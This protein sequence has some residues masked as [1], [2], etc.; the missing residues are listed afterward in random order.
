VEGRQLRVE[1]VEVDRYGREV[2]RV[3]VGD[4]CVACELVRGGHAWAYREHLRDPRLLELEAGARDARRGLWAQ[5][6]HT[7]VPPWEWRR[8]ARRGAPEAALAL[9]GSEPEAPDAAP[10]CGRKRYCKEMTSCAEAR[11]YH[12][13]C[14]IARLDGDGDGVACEDLCF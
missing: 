3:F 13:R 6:A 9:L 2:S 10:A 12:E 1:L 4:T 14:N 11:F 7:F 5:P 8:G